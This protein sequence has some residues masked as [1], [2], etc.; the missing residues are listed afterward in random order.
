MPAIPPEHTMTS[1]ATRYPARVM[2]TI[3]DRGTDGEILIPWNAP[4]H[5][6]IEALE[7]LYDNFRHL[8]DF[9]TLDASPRSPFGLVF[10][11]IGAEGAPLHADGPVVVLRRG[12]LRDDI[13]DAIR[14]NGP[15]PYLVGHWI[16]NDTVTL[17]FDAEAAGGEGTTP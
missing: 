9:Y 12:V 11:I 1:T 3:S 14:D 7:T 2:T 16:D 6:I 5:A 8:T 13:L 17:T 15:W 4:R 10:G